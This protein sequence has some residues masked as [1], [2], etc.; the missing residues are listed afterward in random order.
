MRG[1]LLLIALL[2]YLS[3]Q[4]HFEAPFRVSTRVTASKAVSEQ[5]LVTRIEP[6]YPETA[7]KDVFREM[8]FCRW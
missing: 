5:W 2:G 7:H 1:V 6:T 8:W 3:A 4:E